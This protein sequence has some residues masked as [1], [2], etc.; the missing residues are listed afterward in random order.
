MLAT[1]YKSNSIMRKSYLV[2]VLILKDYS[3]YLSLSVSFMLVPKIIVTYKNI[4]A[5]LMLFY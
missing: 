3:V 1:L 4:V 2:A 5:I